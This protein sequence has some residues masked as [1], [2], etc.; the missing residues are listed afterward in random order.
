MRDPPLDPDQL[1]LLFSSH[2]SAKVFVLG[3]FKVCYVSRLSSLLCLDEKLKD[4]EK[5]LLGVS[6]AY[7]QH[8]IVLSQFE[9]YHNVFF[10][11]CPH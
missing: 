9:C 10:V 4:V 8:A 5:W 2:I 3:Q 1:Q 6:V 7:E 11:F